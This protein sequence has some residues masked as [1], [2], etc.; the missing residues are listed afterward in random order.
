LILVI[1][2]LFTWGYLRFRDWRLRSAIAAQ[3]TEAGVDPISKP[4][5]EYYRDRGTL[6]AR[7]LVMPTKLSVYAHEP[8]TPDDRW[9]AGGNEGEMTLPFKLDRSL[10]PPPLMAG[11]QRPAMGPGLVGQS[12]D[13]QLVMR[14]KSQLAPDAAPLPTTLPTTNPAPPRRPPSV[15]VDF[16]NV[17][18]ESVFT[19][20]VTDVV[21]GESKELHIPIAYEQLEKL[22]PT[23]EPRLVFVTIIGM[24]DG[25][26]YS[27][28]RDEVRIE[29]PGQPPAHALDDVLFAGRY[30]QFGQQVKGASPRVGVYE[31][32]DEQLPVQKT[33]PFEL[34]IGIEQS[35]NEEAAE[36][37]Y[38]SKLILDFRNRTTGKV[39]SKEISPET[40]RPVYF[41]VESQAVGAGQFDVTVRMRT[42]GWVGLK[43]IQSSSLKLVRND[44]PFAWNLLKSLMVLWLMSLLVTIISI[45]CSTFLS[46]PIA[47]VLTIVILFG[48]WG[49]MQLGDV[50]DPGFGR[51]VAEDM[52]K[53]SNAATYRT[54]SE[55]VDALVKMMGMVSSVLPDVSQFG[56]LEHIQQGVAIPPET[57]LASLQVALGFGIP[58]L[59]LSYVF[60]KYKEVAP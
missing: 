7:E 21:A 23:L 29:I 39:I 35:R 16:R 27:V 25:Y 38:S 24:A 54:V 17:N 44:Q 46:W 1:M 60:L 30:G 59:V 2:G 33:Y 9:A 34:R 31:F 28:T 47:V 37:D 15:M 58:L 18:A 22:L 20:A 57:I 51:R 43:P 56:A 6:H 50:T 48:R 13:I 42:P 5:L 45:F 36:E 55:S 41:D 3:L 10:V 11:Q 8:R 32:R 49:A 14:V 19:C 40:N 52:F 53:G 12:S 26:E 4:T